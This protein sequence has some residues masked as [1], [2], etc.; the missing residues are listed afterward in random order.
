MLTA[1]LSDEDPEIRNR[2]LGLCREAHQASPPIALLRRMREPGFHKLP[3]QE[4]RDWLDTLWAVHRRCAEALAIELLRHNTLL[5]AEPVEQ[6]RALAAELLG[7]AD[8]ADAV[9]A[10]REA[11]SKWRSSTRVR[12]AAARS[13]EAID[14]R[15]A[16]ARP[17]RPDAAVQRAPRAMQ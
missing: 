1:L 8:S 10:L 16:S 7:A 14:A 12:E 15:A 3:V 9:S 4:R 6:T 11:T 5:R 17:S 2:A 13:L